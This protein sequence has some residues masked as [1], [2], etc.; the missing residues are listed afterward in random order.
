MKLRYQAKKG[1]RVN[2]RFLH[3]KASAGSLIWYCDFGKRWEHDTCDEIDWH[4]TTQKCNSIRAFRRKLKKAPYGV[5]FVLESKYVGFDVFGK[6]SNT[7]F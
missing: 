2:S 7:N 1:S 3:V 4:S 6:G 5:E